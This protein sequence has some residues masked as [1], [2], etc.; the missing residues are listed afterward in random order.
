MQFASWSD[1]DLAAKTYAVTGHRKL[2]FIPKDKEEGIIPLPDVL[3]D[4]LT[5]RRKRYPKSQLIFLTKGNNPEGHALRIVKRLALRAGV[6][7]GHCANKQGKSCATHP[8]C[9]HVFLH[10]L[11]KTYATTLHNNGVS[12]RT[13]MGFLRHSE[14]DTTLRY[15]A[16]GEDEHP[17]AK[18]NATFNGFGGGAA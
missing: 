9:Y 2:G 13:I 8:V 5:A 10:K 16:D 4:R 18:V 3:V 11:R 17:R 14:L 12:A 15:L 7:C 1:I 6:N